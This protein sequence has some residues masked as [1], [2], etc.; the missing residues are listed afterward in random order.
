[1]A[2]ANQAGK[3]SDASSRCVSSAW[4]C[5]WEIHRRQPF[6]STLQPLKPYTIRV[7][8]RFRKPLR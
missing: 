2:M 3:L 5:V 8:R 6:F 1:M 7:C 4:R